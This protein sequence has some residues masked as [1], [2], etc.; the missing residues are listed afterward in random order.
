MFDITRAISPT[1]YTPRFDNSSTDGSVAAPQAPVEASEPKPLGSGK[2]NDAMGKTEFLQLLVA[3]M[4]NQDPLN[5]M[6][7]QEMAAQLA[8]FTQVE[9]LIEI[10][11][12]MKEVSAGQLAVGDAIDGLSELTIAQGDAMAKL[13]E[14]SMAINTVGRTGVLD[15]NQMFVDRDGS[16][17]IT[18]DSGGLSGTGTLSVL[19][20]GGM[21]IGSASVDNVKEGMQSIPL[22]DFTFDPPLE[23]GRYTYRF[24]MTN[25]SGKTTPVKT[26]TTGRITGLR[27]EQGVP[28]LMLGD[29]LSVPFSDLLQLRN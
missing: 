20:A 21:V 15:G 1:A 3:Q 26:Y 18:I 24:E 27:Y 4:K 11:N 25:D 28:V 22:E 12:G 8:Q 14:Q 29:S 19:D 9:Q 7:G 2:E 6:D 17:A 10:N 5:P 23:P 13:L 16:G